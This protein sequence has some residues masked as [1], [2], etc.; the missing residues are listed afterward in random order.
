MTIAAKSMRVRYRKKTDKTKQPEQLS[1]KYSDSDYN[2]DWNRLC[3][4]INHLTDF[5]SQE[6]INTKKKKQVECKYQY[7]A[8]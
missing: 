6:N 1:N 4:K 5:K 3:L 8:R 2:V 7:T